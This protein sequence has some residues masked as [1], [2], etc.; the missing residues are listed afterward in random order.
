MGGVKAEYGA[1]FWF[2]AVVL[3]LFTCGFG[4]PIYLW[5]RTMWVDTADENGI[6]TVSGRRFAWSELTG[7]QRTTM[8]AAGARVGGVGALIFDKKRVILNTLLLGNAEAMLA[9]VETKVGSAV[10][11]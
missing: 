6:S 5:M 8:T 11:G 10:V 7:I 4:V 2:V 9:F 1:K 3:V